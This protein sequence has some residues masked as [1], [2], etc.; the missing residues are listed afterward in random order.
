MKKRLEISSSYTC[1]P[2]IMIRWKLVHDG[3]G[4]DMVH[5][6]QTDGWMDGQKKWHI[7]VGG[8]PKKIP[9]NNITD[10]VLEP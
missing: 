10:T 3:H 7:E 8:P 2:K 9:Q 4:W 1:L 5:D 6:G